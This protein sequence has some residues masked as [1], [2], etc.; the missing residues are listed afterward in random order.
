MRVGK[1]ITKI[2]YIILGDNM[3]KLS[4][5][6]DFMKERRKYERRE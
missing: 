5:I 3:L 6:L 1:Y 4:I 2:A